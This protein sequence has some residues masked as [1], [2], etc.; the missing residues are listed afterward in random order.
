[1]RVLGIKGSLRFL[2]I[3]KTVHFYFTICFFFK[4]YGVIF[5]SNTVE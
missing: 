3:I 4:S 5:V 1:M 2:A